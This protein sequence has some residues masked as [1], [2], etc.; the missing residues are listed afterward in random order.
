MSDTPRT[1][2]QYKEYARRDDDVQCLDIDFARTLERELAEAKF[3]AEHRKHLLEGAIFHREKVERE[4]AKA[5]A[6]N[7]RLHKALEEIRQRAIE[8]ETEDHAW[9][10]YETAHNALENK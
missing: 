10:Y 9:W 1:N 3:S 4:L 6:D 5:Q 8:E 2:A 7:A